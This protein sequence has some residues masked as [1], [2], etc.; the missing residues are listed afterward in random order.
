M[1]S[2][3]RRE[4]GFNDPLSDDPLSYAPRWARRSPPA[5]PPAPR[6]AEVSPIAP[7]I[8]NSPP[9]APAINDRSPAARVAIAPAPAPEIADA[10]PKAP[11]SEGP[12]VALPPLPRPFAGDVAVKDL[13][14]QLALDP[15]V[16]P[17]PPGR[18]SQSRSKLMS[19]SPERPAA[20]QGPTQL[21]QRWREVRS[22]CSR[23]MARLRV[24]MPTTT[25]T[26]SRR[27]VHFPCARRGLRR[28]CRRR[29]RP[30][31]PLQHCV[32]WRSW[33]SPR[34]RALLS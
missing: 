1:S 8:A 9:T 5:E 14:R 18:N 16:V 25:S 31:N 4:D 2:P 28:N 20:I 34:W 23:R 12:D 13:R 29:P 3:I 22:R 26:I 32:T 21:A 6:S 19:N 10:P 33:R 7:G 24:P 11:G 15:N 17:Q 30:A 27:S